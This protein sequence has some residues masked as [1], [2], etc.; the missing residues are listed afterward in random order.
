MGSVTHYVRFGNHNEQ[1]YVEGKLRDAYEGIVY[2]A[3]LVAYSSR[4]IAN[5]VMRSGLY[6]K[7]F[8][9]N[10]LT[11][12]FQYP[13]GNDGVKASVLRLAQQYGDP[14]E[15]AALEKRALS[16]DDFDN[17]LEHVVRRVLDFQ[18]DTLHT[19]AIMTA[20][21]KYLRYRDQGFRLRPTT[22]ICPYFIPMTPRWL[23]VNL[24]LLRACLERRDFDVAGQLALRRDVLIGNRTEDIVAAYRDLAPRRYFLWIDEF[25]ELTA[26]MSELES[27]VSLLRGL[28]GNVTNLFGGFLSMLLTHEELALLD[29]VCHGPQYGE[30]RGLVPATGGG[31]PAARFYVRDLHQ[32]MRFR[33]VSALF[34]GL[35]WLDSK[36][37]YFD[38]IC[39]CPTCVQLVQEYG[40]LA[41]FAR[42]GR[43]TTNPT[44]GRTTSAQESRV[45]ASN[46]YM[47]AKREERRLVQNARL[48]EIRGRMLD[49]IVRYGSPNVTAHLR[50]WYDLTE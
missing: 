2:H 16:P 21:A 40:P 43:T 1:R 39:S 20:E 38:N 29:G 8:I 3:N 4:G 14:F 23:D 28:G 15:G 31:T 17:D 44:T 13:P 45:H 7:P 26:E 35:G 36:A 5:F 27:F 46:H 12:E 48:E 10:P 9:I 25:S 30:S 42:Y 41:G 19:K 47:Y 33:D 11:H 37:A 50:R 18:H 49:A 32:R 34:N 6:D 24:R 22:L